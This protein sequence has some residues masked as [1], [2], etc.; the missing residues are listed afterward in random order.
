VRNL[1]AIYL[2]TKNKKLTKKN[3]ENEIERRFDIK[4]EDLKSNIVKKDFLRRYKEFYK[5]FEKKI[6][7]NATKQE[8]SN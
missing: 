7:K 1:I 5:K 6:I 2:F 3:I 4:I 8:R